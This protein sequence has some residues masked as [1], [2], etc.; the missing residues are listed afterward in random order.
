MPCDLHTHSHFS[1]GTYSP[2]QLIEEAVA[3]G[4]SAIALTDHNTAS[5]VTEF[6]A[7]AEGKPIMAIGGTELSCEHITSHGAVDVHVLAL[8]LP[9]SSYERIEERNADMMKRKKQSYLEC[10]R[11]LA[12]DGYIISYEEL[13]KKS[14]NLPNRAAI[15]EELMRRGYVG[16]IKEAFSSLLASGGKYY[17]SPSY[18]SVTETLDFISELGAV[19]ILA[20]PFLNLTE[21]ELLTLLPEAK[22]HGLCGMEVFYS[23]YDEKTTTRSIEIAKKFGLALSGGSDFHG[24]RKPDIALG[25][26]QG[27]LSVPNEC[28]NNILHFKR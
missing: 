19:P 4:L 27:N 8:F 11:R 20:H 5:G 25:K 26:G 17:H 18:P 10:E 23:K 12:E 28:V 9:E 1:D 14:I 21:E 16:S 3:K 2:T 6:L 13:C 22:A 15:A 24:S 7:A